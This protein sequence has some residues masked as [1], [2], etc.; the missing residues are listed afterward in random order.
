MQITDLYIENFG[1]LH[2]YRLTLN[3]GLNVICEENGFGKTT[4]AAFIKA[5][6][7]GMP[8]TRKADLDENER[9]KYLPWQGGAYGGT[10]SFRTNGK[11]YRLE[12]FFS[13]G[14]SR[15]RGDTFVLYDLSDH[16]VSQDYSENI[17]LELFGIDAEGYS[18]SAF[19]PQKLLSGGI[20]N[21]TISAKLNHIMDAA[22]DLGRYESAAAILDKR[23]Q[24]YKRQGG[25]GRLAELE[26]EMSQTHLQ[27]EQCLD[28][29]RV[30][31]E[32]EAK[33]ADTNTALLAIRKKR[34]TIKTVSDALHTEETRAAI[35][36]HGQRLLSERDA[37]VASAAEKRTFLGKD[38]PPEQIE[39]QLADAQIHMQNLAVLG[40]TIRQDTQKLKHAEDAE[41]KLQTM[42]HVPN[43]KVLSEIKEAS[44]TLLFSRKEKQRL[45]EA[46]PNQAEKNNLQDDM[47]A[48]PAVLS[49]EEIERH[50]MQA[51]MFE[52][53]NEALEKPKTCLLEQKRIFA[54]SGLAADAVLPSEAA[55]DAYADKLHRLS[56]CT[57]QKDAV[58]AKLQTERAQL[59]EM[60][61]P[62]NRIIKPI[63]EE[64]EL[65][66]AR[67]SYDEL[68]S[69]K[70]EIDA[71]EEKQFAAATEQK[72]WRKQRKTRMICGAVLLLL[73]GALLAFFRIQ[74]DI[75]YLYAAGV[76]CITG[77]FILLF[78]IYHTQN[79][80]TRV[81]DD[82]I[83]KQLCE[84]KSKYEADKTC[85]STFIE[86]YS[87]SAAVNMDAVG[88]IFTEI[89]Q[90]CRKR[91]ELR[92]LVENDQNQAAQL[93][94]E[95]AQIRA[96]LA[97]CRGETEHLPDST[98]NL[99]ADGDAGLIR[100]DTEDEAVFAA[101][102]AQMRICAGALADAKR[103]AEQR[104]RDAI[105]AD[106]LRKTLDDYL[107]KLE[108]SPAAPY[109]EAADSSTAEKEPYLT[110][111]T[112]WKNAADR[113]R[114]RLA[115]KADASSAC[116]AA[117]D[118][119]V[120]LLSPWKYDRW[121]QKEAI[122]TDS[123]KIEVRF[124]EAVSDF[125]EMVMQTT[126]EDPVVRAEQILSA[127]A[128]RQTK[129]AAL[130]EEIAQIKS[131]I[132]EKET[133]RN[134]EQFA[135]EE[136]LSHF[137]QKPYPDMAEGLQ[138]V[139]NTLHSLYDALARLRST[140]N[141]LLTFC[142]NNGI[143][144]EE[145]QHTK[146][147]SNDNMQTP[148]AASE[149]ISL[150][151]KEL[152]QK[153]SKLEEDAEQLQTARAALYQKAEAASAKAAEITA[154]K[155]RLS[156]LEASL[157]DAEHKLSVITKTQEFLEEAKTAMSTR[158][159]G[160]LQRSFRSY[161]AQI[162]GLSTKEAEALSLDAELQPQIEVGGAWR[163]GGYFSRGTG[164]LMNLCIRLAL[165]D[166]LYA[167]HSGTLPVMI[168]DDPFTNLDEKK[169]EAAKKILTKAAETYQI[170]YLVCHESRV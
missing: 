25:R 167:E 80:H 37:L 43:A 146:Q 24:V 56:V 147:R 101:Y 151:K 139:S 13:A 119:L 93:E 88:P 114:S 132:A 142:Q 92:A 120:S 149:E 117:E 36:A 38:V 156:S 58:D 31:S 150:K 9:K 73:C 99:A 118:T 95:I 59:L 141:M 98:P 138:C 121:K 77:L 66:C 45:C 116:D 19:L 108:A 67:T 6:L 52:T 107:V 133:K 159:L 85:V 54:A 78:G 8:T 39:Q 53:I 16:S 130:H 111:L 122:H 153:T 100:T 170:L 61:H 11:E 57:V 17:G 46:A 29:K 104:S 112:A 28:A 1:V 143:T 51:A 10:M 33:I 63:P 127:A 164:D 131:Q 30:C 32:T 126:D 68:A 154:V 106:A 4:L 69:E 87:D 48:L 166:A 21:A 27:L 72:A 12:R 22:D 169:L 89:A 91:E 102:R 165:I 97:A 79:Y 124:D 18:R 134:T 26:A 135:V 115:A 60:E 125:D 5:M 105:R 75:R 163:E 113:L 148:N 128:A 136:F 94:A 34:E 42:E 20:E 161:Y 65:V 145:L 74:R 140:H 47:E 155:E 64:T 129:L 160:V 70:R 110:R 157:A 103:E 44:D 40:E 81:L 168:L 144:E 84:K 158:Y 162:S 109:M 71:L 14:T 41:Q 62:K 49:K 152:E 55:M 83:F 96:D 3:P 15:T 7:Y 23:R 82:D 123:D 86:R 90:K 50:I 137:Y 2:G 76:P 35:M